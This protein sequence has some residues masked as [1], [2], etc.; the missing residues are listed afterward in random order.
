MD[1]SVYLFVIDN[2]SAK[3]FDT[4][5]SLTMSLYFSIVR[6]ILAARRPIIST[7]KTNTCGLINLRIRIYTLVKNFLV[8]DPLTV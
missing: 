4:L 6:Q 8:V 1:S 7:L 5:P 2:E 3:I